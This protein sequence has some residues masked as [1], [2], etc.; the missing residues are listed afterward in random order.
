MKK[1]SEL[2][3]KARLGKRG[4]PV[5]VVVTRKRQRPAE[6]LVRAVSS[7]PASLA[8]RVDAVAIDVDD[9]PRLCDEL[10]VRRVPEL[11]VWVDGRLVERTEGALDAIE[12]ASFVEDALARA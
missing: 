6:D 5:V 12:A 2:D 4:A 11:H 1:L 3:L 8:A 7:L 9:E 10:R